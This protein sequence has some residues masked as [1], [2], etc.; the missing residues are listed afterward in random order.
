MR[1]QRRVKVSKSTASALARLADL[2][3][4][5]E[6]VQMAA[7]ALERFVYEQQ[8]FYEVD[9]SDVEPPFAYDPRW[10]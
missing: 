4:G 10:E 1:R 7:E 5:S 2:P 9:L 3:L 8:A 6:R